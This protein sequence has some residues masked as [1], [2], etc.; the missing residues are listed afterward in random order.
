MST[1]F[2]AKP[3]QL[4]AGI[5]SML[6][7]RVL[8]SSGPYDW[9]VALLR[10]FEVMLCVFL[11]NFCISRSEEKESCRT[12]LQFDVSPTSL[13]VSHV[14][15]C[16]WALGELH[17]KK[18]NNKQKQAWE[19][20][21]RQ[22][23]PCS[24][25]HHVRCQICVELGMYDQPARSYEMNDEGRLRTQLEQKHR[26]KTRRVIPNI[27]ELSDPRWSSRLACLAR[28]MSCARNLASA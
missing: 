7:F 24:Q 4:S 11:W 5:R 12:L 20:L 8:S 10:I 15:H 2:L 6:M 17:P 26:R 23:Q 9:N 14:C 18:T 1:H 19:V 27:N 25:P 3:A 28:L 16:L 22:P 13:E 21:R